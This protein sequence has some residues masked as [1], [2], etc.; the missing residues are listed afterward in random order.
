MIVRDFLLE[1]GCEELPPRSLDKLSQTLSYNVKSVLRKVNLP[2]GKVHT[3]ATPRRLATLVCSLVIQQPQRKI[4]R[5]GPSVKIAF[6]KDRTPTLAFFGFA[7]SCG[8]STSQLKVKETKNGQFIYC[9]IKKPGKKTIELLPSVVRSAIKQLSIPKTM[10]WGCHTDSF[11][12]P[13]HWI[14]M[15]LG[16]DIVPTR[17]FGKIT[18]RETRGHRFHHPKNIF[19]TKPSNYQKLLSTHGMVI[20][21]FKKRQE[22]I[23]N[24]IQKVA[25]KQGEAI[26]DSEL[27]NEVTG[28]VE[29]PVVLIGSFKTEFLKLPLEILLNVM[30]IHQRVFPVKNKNGDLLAHFIIVSNIESKIPKCVV[31]GNER[32]INA[33]L[34]DAS[35]FYN[36]DLTLPLESRFPKLESVI[37]QQRLGTLAD[38]TRRL[39]KLAAFIARKMKIN[40]TLAIRASILSK[41]DLVSK[42][43]YEFPILQGIMGYYYA[44]NDKEHLLVAEAIQDHYLPRFSRDELP[45]NLLGSCIA[46]ADRLDTIIGII[47]INRSS[48]SNKDPFSLRRAALGVLRIL[49]EKEI[50]LEL[51]LVLKEAKKN[52]M[53]ELPNV[54][55]IDQAFDFIIERLRAWCLEKKVT[56]SVFSAVLSTHPTDLLDFH[57]RIKAVEYF[58]NLPE[59]NAL[60]AANK[61]VSNII[62]K[63]T[64]KAIKIETIDHSLFDSDA[65][66]TLAIQ[67]KE[68]EEPINNLYKKADYTRALLKLASLK[69][70]VD[71]FFDEVTVM[72]DDRR[73]RENRI[74]LLNSLQRLFSQIADMSFLS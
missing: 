47:G 15:M 17:I 24:L 33:R 32:V 62:K 18:C 55:V 8:V 42:M 20:A 1:I 48:S 11:I 46:I 54:H 40:D 26:I 52:Y 25:S 61:R 60:I 59:A 53:V 28:M 16:Q 3:Y 31:V 66:R 6:D 71:I 56:P 10:H 72:V 12:R 51:L 35:F 14:V 7:Q 57:R 9:E 74:A 38:K 34:S 70:P 50:S 2:F 45:R 64:T 63:Q 41:C 69:E 27:L 39:I 67:L 73:K 23:Y 49:I 36:N 29:W 58:Q 37:F 22:K 30:K 4:E 68:Q 13:I 44:I 5:Q 43:V 19:I 65:E 21:D